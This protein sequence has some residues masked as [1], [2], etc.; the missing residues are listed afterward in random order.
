MRLRAELIDKTTREYKVI[1]QIEAEKKNLDFV[2]LD[3]SYNGKFY[4]EGYAPEKPAELVA[5]E[6]IIKLKSKLSESDYA[7]IKISEGVATA[8]DYAELIKQRAAWRVRIQE[9]GG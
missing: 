5:A 7:I 8:E 4:Q 6:E 3:F 2:D 9:L 1:N